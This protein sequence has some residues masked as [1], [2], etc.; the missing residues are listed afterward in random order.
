MQFVHCGGLV[1][2]GK[3][4][5]GVDKSIVEYRHF[6]LRCILDILVEMLVREVGYMDLELRV[7]A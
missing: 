4:W 7:E 6:D 1:L 3:I 2:R 5:D